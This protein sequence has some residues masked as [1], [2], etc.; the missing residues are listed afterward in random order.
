MELT[1]ETFDDFITRLKFHNQGGGVNDHCTANPIFIVQQKKRMSGMDG[2]YVDDYVWI[3]FDRGHGEAD[4]RTA[5]RL[6][7]LDDD[8]F[9]E[10]D[11][12]GWEKIYYIDIW[13]YVSA[14]LTKEAA[15]AF[16]ARKK[17]DYDQLRVYVDSQYHCWEYN[18]IIKGLLDGKIVF[19]GGL[20]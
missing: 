19:Q 4:E 7:A 5:R 13:E 9:K 6:D 16:I 17:H 14:H 15:E 18:A 10:R 3:N 2:S 12:K 1:K 8:I 20:N 11:L